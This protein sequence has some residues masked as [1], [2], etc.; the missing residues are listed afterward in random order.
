LSK[1][2][3]GCIIHNRAN[4]FLN[5][6]SSAFFVRSFLFVL[7]QIQHDLESVVAGMLPIS[8]HS[9]FIGPA[10][11]VEWI[12]RF[13]KLDLRVLCSR[14]N[15][16]F[17]AALHSNSKL[18]G[19]RHALL[20]LLS[21]EVVA[22]LLLS[23]SGSCLRAFLTILIMEEPP[24]ETDTIYYHDP[25]RR[26][27]LSARTCCKRYRRAVR[28]CYCI[29]TRRRAS[30]LGYTFGGG[31]LIRRGSVGCRCGFVVRWANWSG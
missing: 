5:N 22:E 30:P 17:D 28:Q 4:D 11:Y 27:D 31:G 23:S 20:G 9:T 3:T 8:Y 7:A 6:S 26:T 12:R 21:S 13:D 2:I 24:A 15:S 1:E 25:A 16:S 29:R 19:L 14:Y 10:Y 18:S